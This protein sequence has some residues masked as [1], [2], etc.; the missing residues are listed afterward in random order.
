M[1]RPRRQMRRSNRHRTISHRQMKLYRQNV[2]LHK[3]PKYKP[4]RL[5][6]YMRLTGYLSAYGRPL[7]QG[8]PSVD[9]TD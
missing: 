9:S 8:K 2:T 7:G 6:I 3:H 4:K 5:L 1:V